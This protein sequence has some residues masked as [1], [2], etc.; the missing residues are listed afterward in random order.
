M[1]KILLSISTAIL[2]LS[3]SISIVQAATAFSYEGW[4]IRGWNS[5]SV[6]TIQKNNTPVKIQHRQKRDNKGANRSLTVYI[7]KRGALGLYSNV[8]YQTFKNDVSGSMNRTLYKGTYRLRFDSKKDGTFYIK[9]A[10][11]K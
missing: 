6:T 8:R 3:F 10:F 9:G 2:V 11:N 7:Q 1:K 5:Q 4:G